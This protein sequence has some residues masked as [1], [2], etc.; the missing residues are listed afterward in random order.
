[1]SD[2]VGI[3]NAAE[4]D[5]GNLQSFSR[6]SS[7]TVLPGHLDISLGLFLARSKLT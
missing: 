6:F 5:P 1:M 3:M 2:S 7:E 4:P